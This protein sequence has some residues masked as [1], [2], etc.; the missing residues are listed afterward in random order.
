MIVNRWQA[1]L[2]PTQEQIISIFRNEDLKPVEEIFYPNQPIAEHKHPFDEVRMIVSGEMIM[3]V[4][5]NKILLRAGDKI[6]IPSNTKH[7]KEV[8]G[9]E[10][11]VSIY[12]RKVFQS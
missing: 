10:P 11:C 7:S 2:V 5:G 6:L 3:N 4:A 1:P 8:R 12:A 9:E